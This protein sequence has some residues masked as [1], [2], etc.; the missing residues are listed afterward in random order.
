MTAAPNNKY[1]HFISLG[2]FCSVAMELERFGFRNA[3]YPFDWLITPRFDQ[4][5]RAIDTHFDGMLDY[6]VLEQDTVKRQIY[7]DLGFKFS[8]VHDFNKYT[9][10]SK[11]LPDVQEKFRRRIDRF[12]R[13]IAEPTLFL[14]YIN[15][16]LASSD[17][18]SNDKHSSESRETKYKPAELLWI[19]NNLEHILSTIR[20]YNPNND[21]LWIANSGVTSDHIRIYNVEK[22]P[23]D[24]VA[25]RPFECNPE[26]GVL[27]D[28][29]DI[30]GREQ[31][32]QRYLDKERKKKSI[33][34]RIRQKTGNVIKEV[35]LHEYI[36]T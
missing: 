8:F 3:S 21:I 31:N 33:L 26:L 28:S 14:R 2:Y 22:D 1:T 11:Q 32:L 23:D 19:E 4:V 20:Q 16:E 13:D 30:P 18:C 12:Y 35:L 29:F 34:T 10:L 9:P 17:D 6:E 27:F 5:I 7:H 24:N 36:H 25:R 15:D